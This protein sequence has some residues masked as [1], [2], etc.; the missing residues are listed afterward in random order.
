MSAVPAPTDP[1]GNKTRA[2]LESF[3]RRLRWA[4]EPS[5]NVSS[6][7]APSV[8]LFSAK[9]LITVILSV[10]A[11]MVSVAGLYF[12]NLKVDDNLQV[13]VVDVDA[14]GENNAIV[15]I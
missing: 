1:S 12:G 6:P 7:A 8:P 3:R 4:Q 13:R 14:V 10:S 5:Q 2:R 9:D 11:L 15:F